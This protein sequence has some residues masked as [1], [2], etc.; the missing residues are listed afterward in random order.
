[1]KRDYKVSVIIATYNR[2]KSVERMLN[3]LSVQNFPAEDYEVIVSIDGSEDGTREMVNSYKS[4]YNLH[5]IWH[6]NSGRASACNRG[7]R[8]AR[9]EVI[10]ILDDDMEPSRDFIRAHYTA[11]QCSM[12]LGV[13]GAVPIIVDQS[14]SPVVSYVASKFNSHL[15][16]ISTPGYRIQIRDFYSGNFSIRREDM[17]EVGIFNEEFR[18]YGNEDVELA[19]RLLK[20]GIKIVYDPHA[21][22]TQHYEK[23]FMG[24]A[25]DTIAKGKTAVLL[26]KRYPD[27]F[28]ELKLIEYN[29]T[30]WKWRSLRIFLIWTGIL[31]PVTTDVIIFFIKLFEKSNRNIQEKLYSLGLDYFFWLG[32]WYATKNDK[33]DKQLISKIK[34]YKKTQICPAP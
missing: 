3:A 15:K 22:C 33:N 32:V 25:K 31:I 7:I 17:L 18:I 14:S 6:P 26:T 34:S 11:H 24:L 30:G 10:I 29:Y 27:T 23:D 4:N 1:M 19:H 20:S 12:K 28:N 8:D 16:K 21:L 9:G 5:T 2:S 13:I